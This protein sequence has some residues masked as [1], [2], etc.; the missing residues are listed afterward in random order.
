MA[1]PPAVSTLAVKKA[2]AYPSFSHR[3]GSFLA[4]MDVLDERV[5]T[6]NAQMKP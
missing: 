1:S 4:V 5:R 3:D 2:G 6:K